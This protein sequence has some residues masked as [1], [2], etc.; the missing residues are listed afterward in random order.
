MQG[1]NNIVKFI[2]WLFQLKR[3]LLSDYIILQLKNIVFIM[4]NRHPTHSVNQSL[5]FISLK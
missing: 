4:N 1:S 5:F 2:F 3:M